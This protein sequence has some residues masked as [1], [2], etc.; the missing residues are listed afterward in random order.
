[1]EYLSYWQDTEGMVYNE[2]DMMNI[3]KAKY[4]ELQ[5]ND[6]ILYEW[7]DEMYTLRQL[8][9]MSDERKSLVMT[10][11]YTHLR[12]LAYKEV[13]QSSAYKSFTMPIEK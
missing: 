2:D 11:F 4:K 13:F 5:E 12:D 8:W 7:L 6:D 10:A 1:M 3:F 9:E